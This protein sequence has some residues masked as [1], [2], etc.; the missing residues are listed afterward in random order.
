MG[1]GENLTELIKSLNSQVIFKAL[2][3]T[4]GAWLLI[5]GSQRFLT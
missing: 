5:V 4:V 3:I 2:L 1:N